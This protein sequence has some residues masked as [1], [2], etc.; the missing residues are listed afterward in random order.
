MIPLQSP[1]S[2][3][4]H[5]HALPF[6]LPSELIAHVIS[7][8]LK[9]I[10]PHSIENSTQLHNLN[11]ATLFA[12]ALTSRCFTFPAQR[13]LWKDVQVIGAAELNKLINSDLLGRHQTRRLTVSGSLMPVGNTWI[14]PET[15]TKLLDSVKGV[16]ELCLVTL[17]IRPDLLKR[18][19]L[20]SESETEIVATCDHVTSATV[21][22]ALT[23]LNLHRSQVPNL[24]KS[25]VSP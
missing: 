1:L 12:L 23:I 17:V 18:P 19:N 24:V 21:T 25:L 6:L 11:R 9:Y 20:C 8:S 7:L 10:S 2:T 22:G 16:K 14:E 5:T 15:I 13:A 3:M 4:K